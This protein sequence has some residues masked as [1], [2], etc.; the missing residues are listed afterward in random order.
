MPAVSSAPRAQRAPNAA[1]AHLRWALPALL[2]ALGCL[3]LPRPDCRQEGCSTE[4]YLCNELSGLCEL[5]SLPVTVALGNEPAG[6]DADTATDSS[7]ADGTAGKRPPG[8]SD[9]PVPEQ[10]IEAGPDV[11]T[12]LA[13]SC[14]PGDVQPC[15]TA[16]PAGTRCRPGTQTCSVPPDGGAADWGACVASNGPG[17]RNCADSSDNDCDGLPDNTLDGVCECVPGSQRA[18]GRATCRGQQGCLISEDGSSSTW[19]PCLE[20]TFGEP[21]ALLGLG[22]SEQ[23]VWGP[24][25]SQDGRTLLVSTGDPEDLYLAARPDR[26]RS[27]GP[28]S[29]LAEV[30]TADPEGTPFLSADGLTLYFYG[31]RA[32]GG[33]RDLWAARR[34]DA[35]A[36]FGVAAPL[37]SVNSAQPDQKPWLSP[38]ELTLVFDS[39]RPSPF[40]ATNL[41]LATRASRDVDFA[42]PIELPGV[43]SNAIEEGPTLSVDQLEVYFV[44]DR[45]GGGGG[46]LDIWGA[47]RERLDEPF[48]EPFPIESVNSSLD[49]LDLALSSDGQELFFSSARSEGL[50]QIYR[51]NRVCQ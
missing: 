13:P 4:G 5:P 24:A 16:H 19:E 51:S 21:Q 46:G 38:D 44:S 36:E 10:L 23:D 40:G 50:Q 34:G 20:P 14:T 29:A 15:E 12:L 33:D 2:T 35:T 41:W 43:N 42:S 28:L 9:T 3:D 8:D 32:G 37:A 26:G 17:L 30:N 48:G 11:N 39:T 7:V 49:D 22:F 1:S 18:C 6:S 31:I 27:F 25:L 45:A 47:R